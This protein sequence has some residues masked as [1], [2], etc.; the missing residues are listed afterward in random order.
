MIAHEQHSI[1]SGGERLDR[2]VQSRY[3]WLD[4]PT[5]HRLI[6]AGNVALDSSA[7]ASK[8]TRLKADSVIVCRDIPEP[9]DLRP[10]ANPVLP[11]DVV[12]EDSAVLAFSKP[13]GMPTHPLRYE[14]TDTLV[15]AV[16]SRYPELAG[17]GPS[18]LFPALLHR[19]DTQTS[20]VILA[21]GTP[22]VYALM[23]KQFQAGEVEK[24]YIALVHGKA[25]AG[26]MELPLTHQTRTP[27]KMAV[28]R[29]PE[30]VPASKQ[31]AAKSV[32]TPIQTGNS[33][34]LLDVCIRSGVT[35]QIRCHL[36]EA[37]HPIIGDVLYGSTDTAAPRHWLHAGRIILRHP[38]T[39]QRLVVEA[40][41]P[42]DWPS[43]V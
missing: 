15:N 21:A 11:L 43:V 26:G 7:P 1:T 14:E 41:L 25:V 5:V 8:G 17:I 27:C 18:T 24:H 23:R 20:G 10:H 40:P 13:A 31:F 4:R 34:T 36:A 37:G 2:F 12:Y 39:Q 33:T 28:V 30:C 19:L 16:L 38:E 3:P 6:A 42:D 29:R 9:A 35:H 22:R 32:W